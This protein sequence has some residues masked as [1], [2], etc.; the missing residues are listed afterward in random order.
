MPINARK[1]SRPAEGRHHEKNSNPNL[2]S[3]TRITI[4]ASDYDHEFTSDRLPTV[5]HDSSSNSRSLSHEIAEF[6]IDESSVPPM[7]DNSLEQVWDAIRQKKEKRMAKE[8]PKVQSLQEPEE[9]SPIEGPEMEIPVVDPPRPENKT[10]K[11]Q[12]SL[13]VFILHRTSFRESSDGRT[14]I[15]FID[16]QG[17]GK[18]NVHVSFQRNRLVVSWEV[19][20]FSEYDE[21]GH[22]VRERV[23]QNFQR[24]FPLPEGTKFEEISGAMSGRN[25]VLR[26]PNS[27]SFRVENRSASVQS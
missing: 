11:R 19:I 27:R 17:I 6:S 25:L 22:I 24:T 26:Y 8:K 14:I 12:K 20:E 9:F 3:P 13:Y 18:Q 7:D 23:E 16:V 2:I 5:Y 10:L 21:G 4:P 15:A 1:T